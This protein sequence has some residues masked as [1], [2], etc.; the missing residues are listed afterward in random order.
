MFSNLFSFGLSFVFTIGNRDVYFEN[1]MRGRYSRG[2]SGIGA[3]AS[4]LCKNGEE[5]LPRS[6]PKG[7]LSC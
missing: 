4:M 5:T 2:F 3:F 1:R 6:F 7:Y